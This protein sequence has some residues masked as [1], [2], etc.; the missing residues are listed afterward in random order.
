MVKKAEEMMLD[1]SP[2][3]ATKKVVD[4][5]TALPVEEGLNPERELTKIAGGID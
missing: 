3:I 4:I 1:F 2:E 5:K